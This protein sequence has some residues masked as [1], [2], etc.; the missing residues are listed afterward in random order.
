[1]GTFIPA[2]YAPCAKLPS[3]AAHEFA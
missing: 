2:R 3:P 1:M